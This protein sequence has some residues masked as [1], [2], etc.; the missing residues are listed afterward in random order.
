[1]TQGQVVAGLMAAAGVALLLLA[2]T[3]EAPSRPAKVKA[4]LWSALVGVGPA[5]VGALMMVAGLA[6][7]LV[8]RLDREALPRVLAG[9]KAA[10]SSAA[11]PQRS[12]R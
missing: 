12:R 9:V 2:L 8:Q 7:L 4:S 6:L 3:R 10:M 11:A 5:L 1:M